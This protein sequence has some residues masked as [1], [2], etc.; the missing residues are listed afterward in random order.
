MATLG[1]IHAA[2][3]ALRVELWTP[4]NSNA[5]ILYLTDSLAGGQMRRLYFKT[6][7][8]A[9]ETLREALRRLESQ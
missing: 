8:D 1:G 6:K 4:T 3:V 2:A 9:V 7:Q 5:V